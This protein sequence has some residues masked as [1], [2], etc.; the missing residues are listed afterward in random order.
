MWE[1]FSDGEHPYEGTKSILQYLKTGK[2][3]AQPFCDDVT[4]E[5]MQKCW[6][7]QP[8]DR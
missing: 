1:I 2:R 3:L 7:Q 5:I 6:L 4:Y 8:K